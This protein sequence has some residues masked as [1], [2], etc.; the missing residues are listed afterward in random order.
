VGLALAAAL[1]LGTELALAWRLGAFALLAA[2]L[3]PPLAQLAGYGPRRSLERDA[4][5]RWWLR[6]GGGQPDYVQLRGRAL[7][8]G[9]WVWLQ[10]RARSGS[11]YVFIDG[12]RAEPGAFRRLKVI[13]RLDP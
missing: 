6:Q 12:R 10:L 8:L 3:L 4:A 9:P 7:V 1:L 5:G 2:A 13:L 11:Q